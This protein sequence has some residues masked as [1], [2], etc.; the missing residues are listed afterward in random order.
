MHSIHLIGTNDDLSSLHEL[1]RQFQQLPNFAMHTVHTLKTS[2]LGTELI[3]LLNKVTLQDTFGDCCTL[4][5]GNNA[6]KQIKHLWQDSLAFRKKW[7]G[8]TCRYKHLA[9]LQYI[10]SVL[11]QWINQLDFFD[12]LSLSQHSGEWMWRL[13]RC[14]NASAHTSRQQI[15]TQQLPDELVA[16][17]LS[18][19]EKRLL[20]VLWGSNLK[21]VSADQLNGLLSMN[22]ETRSLTNLISK[23]NRKCLTVS[24][25]ILHSPDQGYLLVQL[26]TATPR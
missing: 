6:L 25:R 22:P 11:L 4:I 1:G 26:H 19:K 17:P 18:P 9:L 16:V 15:L 24:Y 3:E 21:P 23:T 2:A 10:D 12:L 7:T 8:H 13:Q 14:M 20:Q 5:W